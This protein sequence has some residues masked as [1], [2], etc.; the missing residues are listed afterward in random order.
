MDVSVSV[1]TNVTIASAQSKMNLSFRM[2]NIQV[3]EI[4][5]DILHP[6]RFAY[7]LGVTALSPEILQSSIYSSYLNAS[8]DSKRALLATPLLQK[9]ALARKLSG[10][11][12]GWTVICD[13]GCCHFLHFKSALDSRTFVQA[14]LGA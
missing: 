1:S 10:E 6:E 11:L 13:R 14:V 4:T 3:F 9:Q 8:F 2:P 12:S 5:P 7:E